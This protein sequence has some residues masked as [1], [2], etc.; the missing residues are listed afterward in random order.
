MRVNGR[1]QTFPTQPEVNPMST[2]TDNF[3]D[4]AALNEYIQTLETSTQEAA[5]KEGIKMVTE[6]TINGQDVKCTVTP[7]A[8]PNRRPY[9]LFYV[10]GKRKP[11][12]AITT[13][14]IPA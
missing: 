3:A 7:Q 9:T 11:R 2:T 14:L 10:Q 8:N 5:V 13:V 1:E 12:N 6:V 4:K